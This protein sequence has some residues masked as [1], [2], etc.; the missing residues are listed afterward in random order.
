MNKPVKAPPDLPGRASRSRCQRIKT[1]V[2]CGDA[3][4]P[5]ARADAKYCSDQH[6]YRSALDRA[7]SGKVY[8]TQVLKSGKVSI[9]IHVDHATLKTAALKAGDVIRWGRD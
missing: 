5:D 2:W 3:L 9:V 7:M 6:R 1:C 4:S 8:R